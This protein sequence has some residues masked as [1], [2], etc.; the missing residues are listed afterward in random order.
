MS[1]W[2]LLI[3]G[4][5]E[6]V[7]CVRCR[8]LCGLI[9]LE[10]VRTL[11]K[12]QLDVIYWC[13][14]VRDL[15]G[16]FL[17]ERKFGHLHGMPRLQL[18]LERRPPS[19]VRLQPG[20]RHVGLGRFAQLHAGLGPAVLRWFVCQ[21][22]RLLCVRGRLLFVLDQRAGVHAVRCWHVC[23]QVQL[24]RLRNLPGGQLVCSR[25]GFMPGLCGQL[26]L[27]FGAL[28][29]LPQQLGLERRRW[30]LPSKHML[31]LTGLLVDAQR[32]LAQLHRCR[33]P[34]LPAR[35]SGQRRELQRV[36]GR[37]LLFHSGRADVHSL[38]KRDLRGR[39]QLDL[40]RALH[41]RHVV[42]RGRK[43]MHR[44]RGGIL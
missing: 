17:C 20:L 19:H 42:G 4:Q 5:L 6:Q 7:H 23:R 12:R 39:G 14:L 10:L 31:V 30:R 29:G 27:Q 22:E 38:R 13:N 1:C 37:L 18:K 8:N 44:L 16:Q 36:P 33:G 15:R 2:H 43:H 9:G 32:R 26:L 11:C 40:V 28:Q 24:D 34:A 41:R 35:L 21:F 3:G 25:R